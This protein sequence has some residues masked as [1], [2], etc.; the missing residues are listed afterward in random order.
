MFILYVVNVKLQL[1]TWRYVVLQ[2]YWIN[3]LPP[4]SSS[5][6][7]PPQGLLWSPIP[8]HTVCKKILYILL[9]LFNHFRW[10]FTKH[11]NSY[12]QYNNSISK[13]F[14]HVQFKNVL[15]KQKSFKI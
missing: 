5:T 8:Q 7:Q 11:L 9:W 2:F 15:L 14:V 12:G 13:L 10:M 3:I 4:S 6:W 1:G